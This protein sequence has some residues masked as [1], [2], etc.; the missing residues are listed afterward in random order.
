MKPAMGVDPRQLSLWH[1]SKAARDSALMVVTEHEK[2]TWRAL[3]DA[4]LVRFLG[5][6]DGPFLPEDFRAWFLAR[7]HEGPHHPNV[8]GAMWMHAI[9][10]DW[11]ERTGVLRHMACR[12]SHARLTP[13]WRV[14]GT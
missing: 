14:A 12:T 9:K 4:E 3:H 10:A 13:E 1:E 11:V 7:G 5:Q 2:V 6:V 8:W